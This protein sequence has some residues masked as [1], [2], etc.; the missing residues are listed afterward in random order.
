MTGKMEK[1]QDND[2]SE[3]EKQEKSR[4]GKEDFKGSKKQEEVSGKAKVMEGQDYYDQLI[5]LKADFENYQKRIEK[6]KIN[7]IGWGRSQAYFKFLSLYDIVLHAKQELDKTL[8]DDKSDCDVKLNQLSK[9]VDM[10]FGEFVKVFKSEGI[11]AIDCLGKDFDPM[12]CEV[13]TVVDC[14]E[15][16]DGKVLKEIQ[17]GFVCGGVVL[18]PAKVFIGRKKEEKKA[19]TGEK[20]KGEEKMSPVEGDKSETE[21]K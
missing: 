21:K 16:N 20:Q 19:E 15:K 14:D 11:E 10:I 13:L 7:L 6:E 5:R 2:K 12:R 1:T 18:R 9:G 8:K 17:K 3:G 4:Q